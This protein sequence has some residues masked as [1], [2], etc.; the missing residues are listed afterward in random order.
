MKNIYY[1]PEAS[2]LSTLWVYDIAGSYEFDVLVVFRNT[3]TNRLWYCK[4]SGCSC[5]TPFDDFYFESD[6]NNNLEE[7]NSQSLNS[8]L[9]EANGFG[10]PLDDRRE[11]IELVTK[12]IKEHGL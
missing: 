6:E 3:K 11:L 12:H 7:I 9:V 2:G 4:D 8:F 10:A 5:P 1:S